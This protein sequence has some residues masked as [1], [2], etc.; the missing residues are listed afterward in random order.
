MIES[1]LS[2]ISCD[3]LTGSVT[4]PVHEPIS[5]GFEDIVKAKA[6]FPSEEQSCHE[7]I[8]CEDEPVIFGENI[9]NENVTA[10]ARL[11]YIFDCGAVAE[12]FVIKHRK[13]RK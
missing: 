6:D 3:M 8:Q 12:L 9:P 10:V 2:N 13:H 11:E 7:I 5:F 1:V 4:L